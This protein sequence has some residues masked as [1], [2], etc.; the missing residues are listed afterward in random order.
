MRRKRLL[1]YGPFVRGIHRSPGIHS[2]KMSSN[3]CLLLMYS[4]LLV[5]TSRTNCP[6]SRVLR[7][8][9]SHVMSQQCTKSKLLHQA[10][11]S[12]R[13]ANFFRRTRDD[14]PQTSRYILQNNTCSVWNSKAPVQYVYQF[15][16]LSHTRIF[17]GLGDVIQ[18]GRR[19]RGNLRHLT[20]WSLG[21]LIAPSNEHHRTL[22]MSSQH[23]SKARGAD[24]WAMY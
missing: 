6:V 1:R 12:L 5:W 19:S 21:V 15:V 22:L 23:W 2:Q 11:I 7:R 14:S 16:R 24:S 9:E 13:K 3:K 17:F 4:L 18:N 10:L 20:H 8:H